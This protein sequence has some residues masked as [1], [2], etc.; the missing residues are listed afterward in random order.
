ME[1][2]TTS[3]PNEFLFLS[4]TCAHNTY[5][6]GVQVTPEAPGAGM[7]GCA[8][9]H[10]ALGCAGAAAAGLCC[11]TAQARAAA[12][13]ELALGCSFQISSVWGC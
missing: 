4:S 1:L 12:M 8:H 7:P 10:G 3:M 5:I 11:Q 13:V 6:S 9:G 2:R